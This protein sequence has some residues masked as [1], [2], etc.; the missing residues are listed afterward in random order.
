MVHR[1]RKEQRRIRDAAGEHDLRAGVERAADDIRTQ[2]R[3]GG[4]H[5]RQDRFERLSA[6]HD[7]QFGLLAHDVGDIVAAH[8]RATHVAETRVLR[9]TPNQPRRRVG[10]GSAHVADDAH[11]VAQARRQHGA[12]AVEKTGRVAFLRVLHPRQVLARDGA[13]GETF[14]N[15]VVE[16]AALGEIDGR[17]DTI[18]GEA[19]ARADAQQFFCVL[20]CG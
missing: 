2:V 5:A 18:I 19:R 14:E 15:K 8:D 13:L 9:V 10:I 12:H 16:L 4:R 17:G 1:G 20:H 11:A 7:R 3:I 6:L